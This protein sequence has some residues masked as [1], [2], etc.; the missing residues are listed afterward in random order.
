MIVPFW[1]MLP[2]NKKLLP[3]KGKAPFATMERLDISKDYSIYLLYIIFLII[4]KY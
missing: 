3:E 2:E 4:I 1:T